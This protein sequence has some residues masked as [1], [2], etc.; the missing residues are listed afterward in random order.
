[1][2]VVYAPLAEDVYYAML[3][4]QALNHH[5]LHFFSVPMS[6]YAWNT[7]PNRQVGKLRAAA[8][9][10]RLSPARLNSS[11]LNDSVHLRAWWMRRKQHQ[12]YEEYNLKRCRAMP[13]A[14]KR[15]PNQ[16]P[17]CAAWKLCPV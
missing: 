8:V 10:H 4:S 12:Q 16:L 11:G 3:L 17:C 15:A 13:A 1:M 7:P 9:Y 6:E 2:G 5:R 14:M